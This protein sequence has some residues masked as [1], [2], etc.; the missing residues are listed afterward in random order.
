MIGVCFVLASYSNEPARL[1]SPSSQA[2]MVIERSLGFPLT[3]V[4]LKVTPANEPGDQ[5]EVSATNG[6]LNIR[7]SSP[8]AVCFGFHQYLKATGMGIVSWSGNRVT[9]PNRWPEFP[10]T[11]FN[12]PFEHRYYFNAVTYG[13]TLPYWTWDR[14][15]KEIDWM[16][17]H[18]IDMPLAL[19]ATEAI[20]KRVWRKMGLT[21]K[22]IEPFY[23]GPAHLP[24]QRMGNL[25]GHDGPLPDE[26]DEGQ[27]QLQHKILER[28]R[29]LEMKPIAPAF[30]GF[31]PEA[32]TRIHPS[33]KLRKI[34]W[35]GGL[36]EKNT[37]SILIPES[38]LFG[39]IGEAYIKEW[40]NE[41]GT[42]TYY[43]S[44]SFNEMEIPAEKEE[45]L[46]TLRS[47][48]GH[49][50]ESIRRGN[51]NAVWVM[52][53]WMLGYQPHI[54]NLETLGALTQDV[55]D[56]RMIIL[57][58]A[59]D[60]NGTFWRSE[61]NWE[62]FKGFHGKQ[63]I[64]SLIPNMGGK[65]ALTGY[66]DFYSSNVFTA[67]ASPNRGQLVGAGFAPEGIENNEAIY[68]LVSDTYWQSKPLELDEWVKAYLTA[69]YGK[70]PDELLVAWKLLRRNI[71]NSFTDHPT[72]TWQKRGR[73]NASSTVN[74]SA[75]T[76]EAAKLYLECRDELGHEPLFR[77]DAIELAALALGIRAENELRSAQ[78]APTE[79]ARADQFLGTLLTLDQLL[80]SH[81]KHR[82]S[83]WTEYA[84]THSSSEAMKDYY[85]S[86]AK[87]IVTTWGGN[88]NDYANRIWSGLIR[89]YYVPR[90]TMY[91]EG[92][93]TGTKPDVAAW[94]EQWIRKPGISPR[95]PFDDP[96]AE[97]AKALDVER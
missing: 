25:I 93:R 43:I 15:E 37:A 14:W 2:K 4:T 34:H 97:A 63:W 57:D 32:I 1:D 87:R 52:Q 9:K 26:W 49:T 84:R 27:I 74:L 42:N 23:P 58:L 65:T 60:Y 55:P 90:W 45:L 70:C 66:L 73:P 8:V 12:T 7:G 20:G 83:L 89:D 21:D 48:G 75:T 41:F 50:Y 68:E 51:P 13:Y 86:N 92:Q 29:G 6:K 30:A 64:Y 11:E 5:V 61:F 38:P 69:R 24:W 16:A 19:V 94:E 33:A 47:F 91:F 39:D 28:M 78:E 77:A 44:D 18:G 10:K 22:E 95:E 35:G 40:E 36:P 81:P 67:L 72:F 53:G 79:K 71:Y 62:R 76:I 17:M 80:E 96:L 56:E 46:T 31:V 88:V 3:D 85:E 82:L 59:A 54:W